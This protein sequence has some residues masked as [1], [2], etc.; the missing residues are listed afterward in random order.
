MGRIG[1]VCAEDAAG[2]VFDH[3]DEGVGFGDGGGCE[4]VVEGGEADAVFLEAVDQGPAIDE[5]EARGNEE[6]D[7]F[8]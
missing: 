1:E 6:P 3:E 4:L 2:G 8:G 7:F 5:L